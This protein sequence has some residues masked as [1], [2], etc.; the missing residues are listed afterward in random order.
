M[1]NWGILTL[2]II[3]FGIGQLFVSFYRRSYKRHVLRYGRVKF[4]KQYGTSWTRE[5]ERGI[6]LGHIIWWTVVPLI[7]VG[8]LLFFL[9]G[10]PRIGIPLYLGC[11]LG[12][13]GILLIFLVLNSAAGLAKREVE[14]VLRRKQEEEEEK[15]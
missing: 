12:I 9:T 11:T 2:G 13:V 6:I 15:K 10:L 14:T 4:G 1:L 3:L 7:A 5:D 8:S